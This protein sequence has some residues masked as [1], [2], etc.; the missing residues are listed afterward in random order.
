MLRSLV[1]NGL[2]AVSD[3]AAQVGMT[4]PEF[5]RAAAELTVS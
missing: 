5:E 1:E 4:V 3:A 2:L